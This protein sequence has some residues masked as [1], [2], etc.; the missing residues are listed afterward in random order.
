MCLFRPWPSRCVADTDDV[1]HPKTVGDRT[2]LAIMAALH[3]VGY[4]VLMPFG[5]N[6]RYD[7]VIDDG[8]DL[9]R[10]QRK[11]G[12][13][14]GGAVVF[15]TCSYYA[16]HLNPK[17]TSRDYIGQ[18]DAFAVHCRATG[19]VYLVPIDDVPNRRTGAL[20]VDPPRNNQR[21]RVRLATD[22]EIATVAVT[23]TK[24]LR[25]TAGA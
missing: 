15:N 25:A 20:R 11:T 5:E 1:E 21:R 6:T 12:R 13:L 2:T 16:H 8:R 17:V 4:D 22:Y 10:I 3:D 7:L 19:G 23:P 18:I 9:K 14:Y 24:E